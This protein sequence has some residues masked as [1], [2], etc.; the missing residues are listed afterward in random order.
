MALRV[1]DLN[2]K[3]NHVETHPPPC[4]TAKINTQCAIRP[5]RKVSV[6]P[7]LCPQSRVIYQKAYLE[8]EKS[9]RKA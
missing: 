9:G 3:C 5:P 6:L 7:D 4:K 1:R 2:T 8:Y